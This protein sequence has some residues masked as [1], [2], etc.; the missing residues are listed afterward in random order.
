MQLSASHSKRSPTI[1]VAC[2]LPRASAEGP[3]S[4]CFYHLSSRRERCFLIFGLPDRCH[5]AQSISSAAPEGRLLIARHF[6]GGLACNKFAAR[7]SPDERM[8]WTKER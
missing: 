3:S 2:S 7:L 4:A 6:S 5:F 8:R 1:S